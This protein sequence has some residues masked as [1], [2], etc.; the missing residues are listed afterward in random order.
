L[1][2]KAAVKN[3]LKIAVVDD[4]P[5]LPSLYAQSLVKLGYSLPSLFNNGTSIVNSMTK[6]HQSFDIIIMD[7]KMPEMNG[8][9]AAK[10]IQRYKKQ[11][12][13]ILVSGYDFVKQKAVDA[14]FPF[15]MKPFSL[16]QLADC[17][18]SVDSTN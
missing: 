12:R 3:N 15:L 18:E 8:V 7:Y 4:D 10:I 2:E 13:I 14:G 9:E 11:T 17:L 1:T 6:D 16:N 5:S